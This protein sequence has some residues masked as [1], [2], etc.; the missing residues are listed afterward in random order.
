MSQEQ[1]YATIQKWMTERLKENN[2]QDS[3]VVYTEEKEGTIAG[4][5][6]EWLVFKSK[7]LILDRSLMN[8]Q[9]TV[10]CKPNSCLVEMEKIRYTY[11]ET[12]I[13]KA[14]EWIADKYALNKDKT[15]L[16]RAMAKW[17]RH[18]VDF[19]DDLFFDVAVAFGAPDTRPKAQKKKEEE[20]KATSIMAESSTIVIGQNGN[21]ATG[22]K[23][24]QSN[25]GDMPGYK[26]VE[27]EPIPSEVSDLIKDCKMVV[28]IGKD[29]FNMTNMTINEAWAIGNQA[30]GKA[31]AFCTLSEEQPHEMMDKAERYTLKLFKEGQ[32]TPIAIIECKKSTAK[33]GQDKPYTYAGEIVR[34]LLKK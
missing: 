21:M 33:D 17:R 25:R 5:G 3:R 8:Y 16:V 28:S 31:F 13:Y 32:N 24:T 20:K 30:S 2:N 22:G 14:E 1:I 4:I 19:A 11:R 10:T 34:F 15:K 9:I 26:N 6:E 12:E 27:T 29:E 18:T 7:A 23:A